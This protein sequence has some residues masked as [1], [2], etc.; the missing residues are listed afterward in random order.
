MGVDPTN[1]FRDGDGASD[2][3]RHHY[4]SQVTGKQD[5]ARRNLLKERERDAERRRGCTGGGRCVAASLAVHPSHG[6]G[7]GGRQRPSSPAE[8]GARL[9]VA[10]SPRSRRDLAALSPQQVSLDY[11]IQGFCLSSLTLRGSAFYNSAASRTAAFR[12]F[13]GANATAPLCRC[14]AGDACG[15][16]GGG[17]GSRGGGPRVEPPPCAAEVARGGSCQGKV[18]GLARCNLV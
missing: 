10:I 13:I 8:A 2:A 16:Q 1:V 6:G 17:R 7:A 14:R 3:A 18:C 9:E 12:A 4:A 15:C 5:L 11:F